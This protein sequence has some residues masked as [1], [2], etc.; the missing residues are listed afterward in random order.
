[1]GPSL[2]ES[3]RPTRQSPRVEKNSGSQEAEDQ[4]HQQGRGGGVV[5]LGFI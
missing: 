1:M 4:V 5:N 3:T 2:A